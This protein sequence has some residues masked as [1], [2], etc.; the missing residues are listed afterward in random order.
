MIK[1]TKLQTEVVILHLRYSLN[2][3]G[4]TSTTDRD[5]ESSHWPCI[6][7][8]LLIL[9][10][11]W[12]D[13]EKRGPL[14][15]Y[16][17]TFDGPD[18]LI[19]YERFQQSKLTLFICDFTQGTTTYHFRLIYSKNPWRDR[20]KRI[21]VSHST[22]DTLQYSILFHYRLQR[23]DGTTAGG[24]FIES[25]GNGSEGDVCDVDRDSKGVRGSSGWTE[26]SGSPRNRHRMFPVD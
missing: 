26:A 20:E 6:I 4:K 24:W 15:L 22:L 14:P 3:V 19:R 17:K 7:Y 18:L 25:H 5:D 21:R 11:I 9:R 2:K 12:F 8:E 13:K 10:T 1:R 23:D 16:L